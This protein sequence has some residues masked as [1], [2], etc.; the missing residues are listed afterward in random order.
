MSDTTMHDDDN[1]T[2][3]EA[4]A[5]A[6]RFEAEQVARGTPP[7]RIAIAAT[8]LA[9][10]IVGENGASA[11]EIQ[12]GVTALSEVVRKVATSAFHGHGRQ[13]MH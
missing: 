6:I 1:K 10:M 12:Q 7:H 4:I 2:L 8:M 3:H 5:G 9:A 13:A 11:E